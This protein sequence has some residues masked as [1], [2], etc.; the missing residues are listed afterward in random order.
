MR[1]PTRLRN[2]I[3]QETSRIGLRAL[4]KAAAELSGRYREQRPAPERFITSDAH[5]L[6]YAAIR[7]PATFAAVSAVLPE[8]RRLAPEMNVNSLLDLGAGTGAASWA[9]VEVFDELE[10]ITMF[11]QDRWLIE[12]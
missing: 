8:I 11:E 12:L 10:R 9:A 7:M 4:G 2:A 5:R 1:L 3:E 6:A